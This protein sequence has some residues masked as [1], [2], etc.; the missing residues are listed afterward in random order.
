M[1]LNITGKQIDIGSALRAHV[2]QRMANSA[3]KYFD[4]TVDG[5]VTFVR[6]GFE[7]RADCSLHLASG[8]HLHAQGRAADIYAS[9]ETAAERLEKR[10]RR[11][12]SRLRDHHN[13]SRGAYPVS[14][15]REQVFAAEDDDGV[16]PA[17]SIAPVVV[18]ESTLELRTLTVGEAVMQLDLTD[19]PAVVFRNSAHGEINV[20]YR[21]ADGNIGWIDPALQKAQRPSV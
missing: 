12:K 10:L 19:K 3:A 6:D 15:A 14:P 9:F 5:A 20:V 1:K 17:A 4:R 18:S 7:Y 13:G 16:E 8:F 11:Y 2:E 21:R